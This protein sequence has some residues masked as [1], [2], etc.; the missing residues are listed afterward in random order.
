MIINENRFFI[1]FQS[2]YPIT[3]IY[4]INKIVSSLSEDSIL[5]IYLQMCRIY[6]PMTNRFPYSIIQLTLVALSLLAIVFVNPVPWLLFGVV[7]YHN[8]LRE[9]TKCNVSLD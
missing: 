9:V 6:N 2:D 5:L 3:E 1:N 7:F 8:S 4:L